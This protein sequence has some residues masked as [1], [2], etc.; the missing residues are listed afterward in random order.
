MNNT[1]NVIVEINGIKMEVDLRHARQVY[2]NLRVGSRVKI[3]EKG[4]SDHSVYPGVIVGFEN[5]VNLPTIIVAVLKSD[6]SGSDLKFYS[7]NSESKNVEMVP[8]LDWYPAI[9]MENAVIKFD[10]EI[11]K[12]T[13]QIEDIEMKKKKFFMDNFNKLFLNDARL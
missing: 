5:F 9:A 1:E 10:A 12:L 8:A 7:I 6:Y 2:E 4:Y 11:K 3:L 13:L